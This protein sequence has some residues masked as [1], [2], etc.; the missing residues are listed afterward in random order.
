MN[1]PPF[2]LSAPAVALRLLHMQVEAASQFALAHGIAFRIG[3]ENGRPRMLT[4]DR[5][6]NRVTVTVV[7]GVVTAA[8]PG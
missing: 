6:F 1:G 2:L 3:K 7:D 4:D 8:E 5:K